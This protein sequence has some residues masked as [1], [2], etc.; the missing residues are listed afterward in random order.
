MSHFRK[1]WECF[2]KL[3]VILSLF[4]WKFIE[5]SFIS[6]DLLDKVYKVARLFKQ[7]KILSVNYVA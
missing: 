6:F 7:L 4:V 3:K 2:I 5:L 1:T